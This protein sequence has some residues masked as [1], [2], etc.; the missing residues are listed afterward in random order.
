MGPNTQSTSIYI[1]TNASS[2]KRKVTS[3]SF[4]GQHILSKFYK[5]ENRLLKTLHSLVG[6]GAVMSYNIFSMCYYKQANSQE[7]YWKPPHNICT[8][9]EVTLLNFQCEFLVNFITAQRIALVSIRPYALINKNFTG[10][11]L[12]QSHTAS[13]S[14]EPHIWFSALMSPS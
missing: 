9:R 6:P 14:E 11:W 8:L 2:S 13:H 7:V 10:R 5:F 1:I 3:N 12:V 4:Y